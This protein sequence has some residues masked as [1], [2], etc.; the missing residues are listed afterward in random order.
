[1]NLLVEMNNDT[2]S[3][4]MYAIWLFILV[5][6]V[7]VEI[8][9][10]ATVSIWFAVGAFAAFILAMLVPESNGALNILW[11]F[12][13]FSGISLSTLIIWTMVNKRRVEV[14]TVNTE[15]DFRLKEAPHVLGETII[16]DNEEGRVK[17]FGSEYNAI[18]ID[19]Q[20]IEAGVLVDFVKFK[21][22]TAIVKVHSKKD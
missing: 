5:V 1:M 9:I 14:N 20:K 21:G 7:I 16:S 19:G 22:N 17:M 10:P 8:I 11:E 4:V 15:E 2:V 13:L 18:S 3:I 12:L 6:S